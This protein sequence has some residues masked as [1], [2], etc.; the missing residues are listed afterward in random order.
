MWTRDG[1]SVHATVQEHG[2]VR[3]YRL[4][5]SSAQA[6]VVINDPGTVGSFSIGPTGQ[7]AYAHSSPSDLAQLYVRN[8]Q[9]ATLRRPAR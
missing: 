6:A 2:D 7:I 8:A 9:G 4:H 1:S 5:V 3:L